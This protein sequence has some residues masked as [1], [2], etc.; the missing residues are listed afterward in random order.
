MVAVAWVVVRVVDG[1]PDRL[2]DDRLK[3]R[4]NAHDHRGATQPVKSDTGL[5]ADA[6]VGVVRG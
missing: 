5:V 2:T 6:A 1:G 4:G 3:Q